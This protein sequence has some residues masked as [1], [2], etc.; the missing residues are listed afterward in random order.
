MHTILITGGN[1][2]LGLA[3]ARVLAADPEAHVA[4]ACRNPQRAEAAAAAIRSHTG[5]PAVSVLPLD[6]GSLASVR[7]CAEQFRASGLPPLRALV[8]NAGL[9][10]KNELHRSA[11]GYEASFAV[12]HL[13]HFRLVLELLPA[14]AP[15]GRV[16][17]V[18]SGTHYRPAKPLAALFGIPGGLYTSA[19]ALAAGELPPSISPSQA[20][21]YRYA[22]SKL[23][24]LL[25]AYE[26]HRRLQAAG[27]RITVNA[28]DPGLMPGTGLARDNAPALQWIWRNILPVLR[29]LDGVNSVEH[30]GQHLAALAA[31][32]RWAGHSG[33]Y[34]VE[35]AAV[36]SS[37]ASYSEAAARSLW[38]DSLALSGAADLPAR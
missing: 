9:Q 1:T 35:E 13:G 32:P 37:D 34:V 10:F 27:S 19:R 2:G 7:A 8:C 28:F 25:F 33:L 15:D 30:S 29:L 5:N 36:P 20:G 16:V 22:T 18:S 23:C 17:V 4:L 24:N 3:C 14:M 12:N 6:L 26:L 38:E 31:S 11:D 21:A